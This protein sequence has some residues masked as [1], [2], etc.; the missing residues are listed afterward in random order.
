MTSSKH[1]KGP[2]PF[3]DDLERNPG[4]GQSPGTFATGE[5][6]LILEGDNTVEGD[7]ENDP[8]E[9]T[10]AVNEDQVGRTTA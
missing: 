8:D 5:D 4:I 10:G 3:T 2:S 9:R 7:V 6:P 1:G